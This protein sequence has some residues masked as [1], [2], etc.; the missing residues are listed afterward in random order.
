MCSEGFEISWKNIHQ[1]NN[2]VLVDNESTDHPASLPSRATIGPPAKRHP[3]AFRWRADSG[4]L[5]YANWAV[6]EPLLL[7]T[8]AV[9]LDYVLKC[10]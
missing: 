8:S 4:P 6:K 7:A 10:T 1:L 2:Y 9:K 5:S 3:V